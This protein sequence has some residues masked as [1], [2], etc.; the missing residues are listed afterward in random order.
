MSKAFRPLKGFKNIRSATINNVVQDNLIEYFDYALLDKGNYFNISKDELT[1]D[2][3][4][5]SRLKPSTSEIYDSG[6]AWEGFRG[7]WV[8][9]SGINPEGFDAPIVGTDPN[10]PGISGVYI[11]GNFEPI[12]GVGQ[13]SHHIDYFN[14]RVIFDN[15]I[16]TGT[17][18]QTEYSHKYINVIYANNVPWLREIQTKTMYPDNNFLDIN[19]GK[20]DLPPEARLQL[21]AIAVEVVP[22]RSFKG[23]QLG[24]GQWVY[25]DVLFHCIAEDEYTRNQ[26]VDIVSMQNDKNITSFNLNDVANNGDF[27][28]DY[29][30][31]PVP[32]ALV[33]PDLVDKYGASG[34][35]FRLTKMVVQDMQ[36]ID[37]DVFGGIIRSTVELI[38]ANI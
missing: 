9:Q 34:G 36:T 18:V 24:G 3:V 26:L 7:N 15:P 14:G 21:P 5:Y 33:Y 27:P 10:H 17:V 38:K 23:Y 12:S 25:M 20:W 8:W 35:L 16:P 28:L 32:S 11:D 4:D 22:Q 2:S 13:Y 29:R 19:K 30:G 6:V 37:S 31:M 1:Y